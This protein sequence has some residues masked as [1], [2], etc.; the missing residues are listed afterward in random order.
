MGGLKGGWANVER[1]IEL[2]D[3][4]SH[5]FAGTDDDARY[6]GWLEKPP[7][8]EGDYR[9]F[10]SANEM[11]CREVVQSRAKGETDNEHLVWQSLLK[12]GGSMMTQ[13]RV[14]LSSAVPISQ[15]VWIASFIFLGRNSSGYLGA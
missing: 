4:I 15:L 9:G 7:S 11:R 13:S 5:S 3:D 14:P 12:K 2:H 10:T 6:R 1:A 8:G